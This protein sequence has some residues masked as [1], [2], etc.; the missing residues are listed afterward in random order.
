VCCSSPSSLWRALLDAGAV[1]AFG[2]DA[3]VEPADPLLG[4]DAATAWRRRAGWYPDLALTEAQALRAYTWG[5]AYAAGMEDRL[6]GLRP[7]ML[8]DLT[9]IRDGRVTATVV[10]DAPSSDRTLR[11]A[12][13][14]Y[15]AIGAIG[16]AERLATELDA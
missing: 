11:E 9:L 12:L 6:G 10:G 1:L 16:H 14:L 4:I 8:C 13:D 15:R 3:P 2:S 5:A 7:G